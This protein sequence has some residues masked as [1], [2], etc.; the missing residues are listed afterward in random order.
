MP[1]S[2]NKVTLMGHLGKDPEL[3]ENPAPRAVIVMATTDYQK[4]QGK[5]NEFTENTTW[6]RVY[7]WGRA[8]EK[9]KQLKK[10]DFVYVDGKI[11]N[12]SYEDDGGKKQ[13]MTY[14]K[15]WDMIPLTPQPK[16]GAPAP[17]EKPQTSN[18]EVPF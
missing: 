18:R 1:K 8:V 15:A 14:V 11:E 6:H 10:G 5:E 12:W 17:T 7:V 13:T 4:V 2:V 16:K 9:C 3:K